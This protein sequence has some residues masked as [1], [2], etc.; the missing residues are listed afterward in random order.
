[1]PARL[2]RFPAPRFAAGAGVLAGAGSTSRLTLPLLLWGISQVRAEP[3]TPMAR[4]N[5]AMIGEVVHA[6]GERAQE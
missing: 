1:M 3:M 5:L 4:P 6:I 2:L